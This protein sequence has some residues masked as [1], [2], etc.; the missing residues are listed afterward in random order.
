MCI[1][2]L[3]EIICSYSQL[4]G[5]VF[6]GFVD[7]SKAFNRV[8][9]SMLFTTLLR[10]GSPGYIVRLLKCWYAHQT[11]CVR[12]GGS[13][14]SKFT[15]YNGVRQ[16][17]ILSPFLFNVYMDDLSVN[18]KKC[19]TGC[20]AGGTAVNHLMY[21]DDIVL[22]RPSATGLSLRLHVCEKYGLDHDIIFNSTKSVVIIFRNSSLKDFSFPS[23]EMNGE[24][25]KEVPVVKYLGHVIIADMKDDLDIM[26]QCRQLYA[27]CNALARRVHMSSDNVKVTLFRSYCSSFYT[28]PLWWKYRVNSIRKLYVAYNNAFRMLFIPQIRWW[29]M[30]KQE[31]K[32]AYTLAVMQKTLRDVDNLDWQEINQ[33]LVETAKEVFGETSGKGTYTEKE[34][35][36]WQEETRKAV[37]LKRA[38][39]KQ[40]QMN[41][42]DE[43]KEKFREANRA[44]RKAVR[45]AKDAAY[46]D[47]YAK[48]DSREGI[49][50]V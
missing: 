10:R 8:K 24:S 13:V 14:S 41:K 22:L 16:G 20:I 36:W 33:I 48:L 25:I 30:K 6:S 32:D 23:F 50:M 47:L 18:L 37:A 17:G 46:E 38:T 4:N 34:T 21:A 45:I 42:S 44:S 39:L 5:C 12:W 3:K 29:K 9:P 31:E 11:M 28:S 27:Q 1:Y 49:K 7:A 19:P 35:S 26:R 15:V 43:N 2:S 40:F